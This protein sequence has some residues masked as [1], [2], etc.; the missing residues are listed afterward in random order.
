MREIKLDVDG[1]MQ[2]LSEALEEVPPLRDYDH[3][4]R[5]GSIFV[6]YDLQQKRHRCLVR[7]CPWIEDEES[8]PLRSAIAGGRPLT[9]REIL[10]MIL[11]NL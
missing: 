11:K 3:C 8:L 2:I 10:K 1:F 5:C 4:P 6:E 7:N 9:P